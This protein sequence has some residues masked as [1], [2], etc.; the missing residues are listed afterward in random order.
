MPLLKKNDSMDKDNYHPVS[1]LSTISKVYE[2]AMHN[3]LSEFFDN[4][5]HPYLAAFHKGF[6]CQSALLRLLEDWRKALDNH[7][8]AAAILMDLSKAFDCLLHDLLIKKNC[9]LMGWPLMLSAFLVVI[10]AIE[11]SR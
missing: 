2:R 1:I 5:F 8:I 4:I 3:Q 7:Q 6:G 9:G 10:S 11:C